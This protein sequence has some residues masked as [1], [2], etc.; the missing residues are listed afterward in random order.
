MIDLGCGKGELLRRL[1]AALRDPRRRRRPLGVAARGGAAPRAGRRHVHRGR[2]DR[3][4]DR[5]AV[6]PRGRARRQRRRLPPHARPARRPP[7]PGRARAARRGLLAPRARP[8]PTS[9]RS[10]RPRDEMADYAGLIAAAAEIGLE[11]RYAVTRE[12]RRLRPLRVALEPERRALRRRASRRAR[13]RGVPRVDPQRPPPLR[14]ARRPRDPRLRA[15][16]FRTH[17]ILDSAFERSDCAG[18]PPAGLSPASA[19]T[20]T[21]RTR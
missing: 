18:G 6:R 16:S 20:V 7:A 5:R 3:V 4:L 15:L 10:A 17:G 13:R 2:P 19:A 11:P 14:R 8:T 21:A 12:R 9:R 1:A